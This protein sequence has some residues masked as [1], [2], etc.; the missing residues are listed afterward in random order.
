MP[1]K[2]KTKRREIPIEKRVLAVSLRFL[3]HQTFKEIGKIIECKPVTVSAIWQRCNERAYNKANLL[4]LLEVL[5]DLPREG[6]PPRIID[7]TPASV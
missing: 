2:P 7:G 1:S 5:D 3:H 4:S 6:R